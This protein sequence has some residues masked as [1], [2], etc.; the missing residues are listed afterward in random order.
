MTGVCLLVGS[1]ERRVTCGRVFHFLGQLVA[2]VDV[3]QAWVVVLQALQLVVRRFQRSCW[4]PSARDTRCLSSILAISVRFSLSRNE[5]TS[6]GTWQCTAAV[7]S[8]MD[9][10]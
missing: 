8:F 2:G 7:L 5:A 9:S 4:A 6:T 3:F 10:S 1:C